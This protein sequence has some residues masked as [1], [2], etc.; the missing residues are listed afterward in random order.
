MY[1]GQIFYQREGQCQLVLSCKSAFPGKYVGNILK[2]S[3]VIVKA[4]VVDR[5][6]SPFR[7]LNPVV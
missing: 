7:S 4:K 6:N 5:Q 2:T 1:F 3:Y